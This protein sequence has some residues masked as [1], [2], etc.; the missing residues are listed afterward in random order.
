MEVFNIMQSD[1]SS[2]FLRRV[3]AADA[4]T[5]FASGLLLVFA[6]DVLERD[7]GLPPSL[8]RYAGIS[9]I[10][11]AVFLV[12]LARREALSQSMVWTVIV[13]NLLWTGGSFLLLLTGWAAPTA[14]GYAFIIAQ[15]MGVAVFAALEYVGL[16]STLYRLQAEP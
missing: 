4:L 6:A 14:F 3:L 15:A 10:P 16:K 7:V 11:L 1:R 13:L 8:L 2:I 12:Y 5:C 9:L